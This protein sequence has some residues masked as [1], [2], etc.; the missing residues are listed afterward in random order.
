MKVICM[1]CQ[2]VIRI[3]GDPSD[4]SIS[5]GICKIHEAYAYNQFKIWEEGE[6]VCHPEQE[7]V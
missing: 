4:E 3:I 1:N 2:A 6:N 5:H 7:A